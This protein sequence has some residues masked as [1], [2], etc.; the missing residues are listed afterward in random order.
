MVVVDLRLPLLNQ[1]HKFVQSK[2]LKR[3]E[4]AQ[5]NVRLLKRSQKCKALNAAAV[6]VELVV[7]V[8]CSPP[9]GVRVQTRRI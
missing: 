8:Y 9:L 3:P 2:M 4:L 7:C 1:Q 5:R 6:F